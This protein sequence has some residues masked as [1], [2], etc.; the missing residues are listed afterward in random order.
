[1][2][3]NAVAP[4]ITKIAVTL[5]KYIEGPPPPPVA[6]EI[7]NTDLQVEKRFELPVNETQQFDVKGPGRYLVRV[8]LP[9]GE[10]MHGEASV[11]AGEQTPEVR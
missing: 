8:Q 9:S 3:A 7:L 2:S 11:V 10:V 5:S 4:L 6:G 1:M